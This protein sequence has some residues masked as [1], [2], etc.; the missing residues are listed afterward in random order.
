MIIVNSSSK[1]TVGLNTTPGPILALLGISLMINVFVGLGLA[2]HLVTADTR[3]QVKINQD[4][5]II[6]LIPG[7]S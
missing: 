3:S 4:Q 2:Q 7:F 1:T 6:T 5:K